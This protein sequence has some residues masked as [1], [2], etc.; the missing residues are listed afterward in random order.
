M[1]R[2]MLACVAFLAAPAF[3]QD[4]GKLRDFCGD[5]PGLGTP[6]CTVDPGHLQVEVGLGDWTLDKQP[7]SRT[8]TL[9]FGDIALRYGIGEATELRLG[10]TAYGHVRERDRMSGTLDRTGGIGDVTLGLKQN[11][12]NPDGSGLSVA[13]L[14][15]ATLPSGHDQVS[16]G[17]WGAGL[18]VPVNYALSDAIT[19]ELTPEVDAAPNEKSHH[20][21]LAYGTVV[22]IQAKVTKKLSATAEIQEMRDRDPDEHSTQSL[23]AL[24]LAYQPTDNLQFDV[25][26]FA[27]LNHKTPDLE[28]SFGVARRF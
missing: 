6:A 11:L 19:L 28:L 1:M 27:G 15:Y 26:A 17:T 24:S 16:A 14:P 3:A 12:H 7:D 4:A 2:T 23:A 8:D 25:G 5:R 10:W 20:R 18:L 22:G 9:A 21:H 13:L